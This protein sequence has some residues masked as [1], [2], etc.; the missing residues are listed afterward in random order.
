MRILHTSD[1]HLG[2]NFYNRNRSAE[3]QAFLDWLIETIKKEDIDVL[4]V[5][6][7]IFDTGAP[8]SYAR[9]MLNQFV[10][11]L[12]R[13]DCQLLLLA[14]NHDSVAVLNECQAL[15][16]ALNC[17][18]VTTATP[19]QQEQQ[20]FTLN[21]KHGQAAA[22]FCA[23]PF[24]RPRDILQADES[25]HQHLQQAITRHYQN[26]FKD[27][28]ALSQSESAPLPIIGSG[29]LTLLNAKKTSSVRDIYIGSLEAL[30]ASVLP[31]FDYLALG[32]IHQPQAIGE[33]G[34]IRYSGS[35]LAMSFDEKSGAKSVVVFDTNHRKNI[36]LIPVPEFQP[37]RQISCTLKELPAQLAALPPHS[38]EYW[39]DIEINATDYHAKVQQ[40]VHEICEDYPVEV[41]LVRRAR[42]VK[43]QSQ[44]YLKTSSLTE[45]DVRDVFMQK[46]AEAELDNDQNNALQTRFL[47]S[48][49]QIN[50]V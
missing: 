29:H 50:K 24:L 28:Q 40:Q 26:L 6:G 27:A 36:R 23:V 9:K 3:H 45:L 14:G 11:T 12:S 17:R 18:L 49:E 39:L 1:W 34:K 8:A 15:Y 37:L 42:S 30:P 35:P 7:D 41:L 44:A 47:Q 31:D 43:N 32:H 33:S 4:L 13:L 10:V 21:D 48:L 22:V 38:L 5:A 16:A 19:V 20:I 25:S 2:Q 46:L